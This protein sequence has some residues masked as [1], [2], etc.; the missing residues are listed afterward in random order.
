LLKKK[1]KNLLTLTYHHYKIDKNMVY[2]LIAFLI[3]GF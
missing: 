1:C 2:R 3:L